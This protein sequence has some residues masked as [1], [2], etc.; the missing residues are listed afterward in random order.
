MQEITVDLKSVGEILGYANLHIPDYQRPYKWERRH[1][2]NLFYDICETI[3]NNIPE[4]RLG[5]I[6][7]HDTNT[8]LDIVDGQQRLVSLSL[9]FHY[10]DKDNLFS[11]SKNLFHEKYISISRKHA[12]DNLNE[13]ENLCKSIEPDKS[14]KLK[15]FFENNCRISVIKM[16]AD[17]LTDAF[18]LFDSQNNRG[19]ALDP[20]DLLKAYHLRAIRNPNENTIKEWEKFVNCRELSLK[21]LFD[22]HLFRIRRWANGDSGL[23]KKKHGSEL[24]FS[25]RFVDDFK[26]VSL[27][28]G[29]Y[30][31]LQLYKELESHDIKFPVSIC[32]PI[33]NGENFFRYIEYNHDLFCDKKSEFPDERLSKGKF[34]RNMNLYV[35]MTALFYDRFGHGEHDRE[36]EEKIFVWAFYPRIVSKMIYDATI[37]N[38]AGTGVFRKKTDFQKLF[39]KLSISATPREFIANINM[40]LLENHTQETILELLRDML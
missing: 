26:G 34:S 5:S 31:Y 15:I 36:M 13:W 29:N 30:P 38:Y 40:D 12:K 2:A 3:E 11:G 6:I 23:H 14:K 19:K 37:A 21:D 39:Q 8:T 10:L 35:N 17:K 25:E 27:E 16:P 24:K 28:K 32:M 9:L 4:Y 7:L 18:Q 20:H 22:K 33:I 1:I